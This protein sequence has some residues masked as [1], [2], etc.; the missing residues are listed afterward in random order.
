MP[1]NKEN[2]IEDS[3]PRLSIQTTP[4]FP[5]FSLK[6]SLLVFENLFSLFI[7]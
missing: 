1:E 7:V 5:G 2:F 3:N 4:S 6:S